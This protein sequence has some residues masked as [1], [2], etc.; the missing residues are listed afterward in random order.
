[1][2][3]IIGYVLVLVCVFGVYA[4]TGG[5]MPI[6]MHA[7][8]HE[9]AVILGA[10]IGA[11]VV[12]NPTKTLKAV[13]ASLPKLFQGSKYTKARYMALMA[14]LYDI[15]SKVRK[16]GMMAIEGDIEDP[17]KSALFQKHATVGND[18]H[19]TEFV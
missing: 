11:F 12:A 18:H 3:V 10:A 2:F 1:M 13:A 16:E 8:P 7:A 6:V 5:N 4:L 15:L 19:L 14:L 17:H 9:M